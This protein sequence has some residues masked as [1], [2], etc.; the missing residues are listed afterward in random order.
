MLKIDVCLCFSPQWMPFEKYAAQPY[1]MKHGL[2]KCITDICAAKLDRDYFGF[3]PQPI[4]SYTDEQSYLY[5]NSRDL[6][7][8]A[9]ANK[10]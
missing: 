5:V 8:P 6:N 10:T 1:M 4:R 2:F 9:S 3:T 7:C